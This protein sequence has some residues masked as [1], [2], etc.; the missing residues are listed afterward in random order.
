MVGSINGALPMPPA[1]PHYPP[2]D[3]GYGGGYGG[4]YY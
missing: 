1:D 4:G 3:D 2:Y